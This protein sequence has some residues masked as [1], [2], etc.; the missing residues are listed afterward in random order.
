MPWVK[1]KRGNGDRMFPVTKLSMEFSQILYSLQYKIVSENLNFRK[2]CTWWIRRFLTEDH[3]KIEIGKFFDLSDSLCRGK[4]WLTFFSADE[5]SQESIKS[6]HTTSQNQ[7]NTATAQDHGS[8]FWDRQDVLHVDF[9]PQGGTIINSEAYC[10]ILTKLR[11]VVQNKRHS[12]LSKGILLVQDNASP[13][14]SCLD[15][16]FGWLFQMGCFGPSTAKPRPCS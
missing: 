5:H 13:S 7:T 11:R 10:A 2:L 16:E 9:I 3:K 1:E 14:Y 12:L 15:S 4:G 8:V 6:C